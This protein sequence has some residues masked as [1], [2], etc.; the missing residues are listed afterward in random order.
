VGA[1]Q[2]EV[3]ASRLMNEYGVDAV[4]ETAS[5]NC[6]RWVTCDDK[7]IMTDFQNSSAGHQLAIDAAENLAYLATSAVNLRVTQERWP[8]IV[9]HETREHASKLS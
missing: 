5:I 2:F 7:K 1:L 9:F 3:V 4:F 8:Q 6:A